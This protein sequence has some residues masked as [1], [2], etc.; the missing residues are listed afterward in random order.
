VSRLGPTRRQIA[1]FNFLLKHR[2]FKKFQ[3]PTASHI[4]PKHVTNTCTNACSI[5]EWL[6]DFSVKGKYGQ[7]SVGGVTD[8]YIEVVYPSLRMYPRLGRV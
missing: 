8:E 7:S 5:A 4:V 1:L 2:L 6:M 3:P